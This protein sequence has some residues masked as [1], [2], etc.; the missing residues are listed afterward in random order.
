MPTVWRLATGACART[1]RGSQNVALARGT[2]GV[3]A[4]P[5]R[6]GARAVT[7]R[8]QTSSVSRRRRRRPALLT[9]PMTFEVVV[10]FSPLQ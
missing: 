1:W 9:Q 6:V 5:D 4:P 7:L 8:E 10:L 2:V 3:A